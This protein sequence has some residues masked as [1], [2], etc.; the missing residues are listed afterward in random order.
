MAWISRCAFGLTFNKAQNSSVT[1]MMRCWENAVNSPIFQACSHSAFSSNRTWLS[2]LSSGS[3]QQPQLAM[4]VQVLC[5]SRCHCKSK[6][7]MSQLDTL[8]SILSSANRSTLSQHYATPQMLSLAAAI[9]SRASWTKSW[10]S[11]FTN[12]AKA[13]IYSL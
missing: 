4:G 12:L 13:G 5:L 7:T 11:S 10:H 2:S 1:C 8:V 6:A 3:R 9:H